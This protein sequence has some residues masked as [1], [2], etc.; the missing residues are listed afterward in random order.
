[1][2]GIFFN[3]SVNYFFELS[4]KHP[5]LKM[6]QGTAIEVTEEK[7]RIIVDS[8]EDIKSK[9]TEDS[10]GVNPIR[11]YLV[12]VG[13]GGSH[14][15]M[16]RV[17]LIRSIE[18]RTI[19]GQEVLD[20]WRL[21]TPTI[22]AAI[23]TDF[24]TLNKG[25]GGKPISIKLKSNEIETLVNAEQKLID[26]LRGVPGVTNINSSSEAGPLSVHV[27]IR[28][29]IGISSL[30]ESEII[31]TIAN[32]Y[33]GKSVDFFY[34]Q[35]S[36][37]KINLRGPI[38]ERL[39]LPQLKSMRL[40]NGLVLSQVADLELI[41]G[42]ASIRRSN[43]VKTIKVSADV[44]SSTGAN[45]TS[46]NKEISD[47]FIPMLENKYPDLDTAKDEGTD[48]SFRSMTVGFIISLLVIYLL[49]ATYFR[50]Y[51]E[52]VIV[53]AAIFI[54]LIGAVLGHGI[55]GIPLSIL[56]GFGIVGLAGIVVNDSVIIVESI[57]NEVKRGESIENALQNGALNRLL[58]IFLTSMTLIISSSPL[59]FESSAEALYLIP[60]IIS[61]VFGLA[62]STVAILLV[63]PIGYAIILDQMILL[64]KI[65][66]GKSP[67]PEELII[68]E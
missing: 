21:H 34:G 38:N 33:H 52:P 37:V 22:S 7:V 63:I 23:S 24:F 49:L 43:G 55:M 60:I 45:V 68:N 15:A 19:T 47:V 27:N 35:N 13:V 57:K 14:N 20:L 40:P 18:G 16:V 25:I 44:A 50:S 58:P 62:F 17:K 41:R 46:I 67:T 53:M 3:K 32:R 29:D 10:G 4:V 61:F 9:I 39:N 30:S 48:K 65:F 36:E 66:Y 56:S 59:L 64:N 42:E 6:S 12:T 26:Y 8:L 28:N 11:D 1:M 31:A 51:L 54:S 2:K 5:E